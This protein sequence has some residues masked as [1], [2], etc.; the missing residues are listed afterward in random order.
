MALT[1]EDGTGKAN[2]DSYI[3]Q[4]DADTYFSNHDSPTAWTGLTSDQKDAA[5]RY[6][7]TALDGLF[8]W[9]GFVVTS[10]QALGWPR[11]GV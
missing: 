3:S 5:L 8:A 11:S 1:V 2:A 4:T 7:T 9:E 10:T 6:A